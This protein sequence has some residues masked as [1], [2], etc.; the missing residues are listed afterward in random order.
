[1]DE[2]GF[3]EFEENACRSFCAET[4]GRPGLRRGI[5]FRLLMVGYFGGLDSERAIAW[6]A[7]DSLAIRAFL[8]IA[9]GEQ[10]RTN[11]RCRACGD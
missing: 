1:L 9:V 8:Q 5:Y 3:D 7:A 10:R 2:Y 4:L 11:R 6:R